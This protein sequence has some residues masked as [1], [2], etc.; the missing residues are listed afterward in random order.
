MLNVKP[1]PTTIRFGD[2][3]MR[4]TP[5]GRLLVAT[6]SNVWAIQPDTHSVDGAI[7]A[8]PYI[9]DDAERNLTYTVAEDAPYP[10]QALGMVHDGKNVPFYPDLT[11]AARA[12]RPQPSA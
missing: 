7:Q 8:I 3:Y 6:G 5:D 11:P 4:L 10:C 1:D 9:S 2:F 12:A